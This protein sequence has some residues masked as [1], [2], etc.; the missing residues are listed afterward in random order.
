MAAPMRSQK[1]LQETYMPTRAQANSRTLSCTHTHTLG[2][3]W[4]N[5][6]E[7]AE[8]ATRILLAEQNRG[9]WQFNGDAKHSKSTSRNFASILKLSSPRAA[10]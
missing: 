4:L 9:K 6:N 3:K 2:A 8:E 7:N 1:E 10:W 5:V